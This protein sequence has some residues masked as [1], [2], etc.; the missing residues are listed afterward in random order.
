VQAMPVGA[1]QAPLQEA[2]AAWQA[3]QAHQVPPPQVALQV[4]M[5]C[6]GHAAVLAW[7]AVSAVGLER[8]WSFVLGPR[9]VLW[10]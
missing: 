10:G 6:C 8:V 1:A 3:Q 5:C 7:A 4:H 9:P 2:R